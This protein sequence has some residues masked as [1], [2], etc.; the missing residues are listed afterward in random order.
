MQPFL[1]RCEDWYGECRCGYIPPKR[2]LQ[3]LTRET[4]MRTWT[5]VAPRTMTGSRL[6]CT[7]AGLPLERRQKR[8]AVL[9][10]GRRPSPQRRT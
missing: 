9:R 8:H 2:E 1:L 3:C 5:R 4:A 7:D 6:G 10:R